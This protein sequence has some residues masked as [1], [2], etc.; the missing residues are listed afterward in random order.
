MRALTVISTI[1]LLVP[2]AWCDCCRVGGCPRDTDPSDIA[3]PC[4]FC[5]GGDLSATNSGPNTYSCASCGFE[6]EN[7]CLKRSNCRTVWAGIAK[8]D[9]SSLSC[10]TEQTPSTPYSDSSPAWKKYMSSCLDDYCSILG[11]YLL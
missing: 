2:T 11:C 4:S 6:N 3:E 1:L 8:R 9:P 5:C 10:G 7:D